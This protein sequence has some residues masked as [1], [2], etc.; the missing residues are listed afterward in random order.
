M[1]TS[2]LV[3]L[4]ACGGDDGPASETAVG[5]PMTSDS[6]TSTAAAPSERLIEVNVVSGRAEGGV[7]RDSVK[8]GERVRL[9]VTSD[10]ADEVHVHG[11][12]HEFDIGPDAPGEVVFEASIPGV[13]EVELHNSHREI[14]K[15]EVS[16]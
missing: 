15:L 5:D 4:G 14:L 10:T 11:Y 2:L 6:T 13:F 3:T 7:R 12:D 8:L 1:A 9:R 16:P